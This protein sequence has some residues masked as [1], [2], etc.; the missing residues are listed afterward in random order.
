[1]KK[2]SVTT[3]I[4]QLIVFCFFQ[5]RLCLPMVAVSFYC[6]PWPTLLAF[7]L[8]TKAV[9]G[10]GLHY[11]TFY[12]KL[13]N[14]RTMLTILIW[15]FSLNKAASQRLTVPLCSLRI[16][17]CWEGSLIKFPCS[18]PMQNVALCQRQWGFLWQGSSRLQ[19]QVSSTL[20]S[21][22][23]LVTGRSCK[24]QTMYSFQKFTL[25]LQD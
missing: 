12:T 8:I 3:E 22:S 16:W 13:T 5:G 2:W 7:M 17:W 19:P 24:V 10:A 14:L 6:S 23:P 15:L 1:M 18:I 21:A 11:A 25:P 20:P 4:T 9:G